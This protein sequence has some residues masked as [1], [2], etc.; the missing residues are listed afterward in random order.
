MM[1]KSTIGGKWTKPSKNGEN[2]QATKLPC[3]TLPLGTTKT[4]PK[5]GCVNRLTL[6]W[7]H[8]PETRVLCQSFKRTIFLRAGLASWVLGCNATYDIVMIQLHI[9]KP[10]HFQLVIST[11]T[12]RSQALTRNHLSDCLQPKDS[13]H[14]RL[15]VWGLLMA[16][17]VSGL[18]NMMAKIRVQQLIWSKIC[19]WTVFQIGA[20]LLVSKDVS[21]IM[22]FIGATNNHQHPLAIAVNS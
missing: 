19:N 6:E 2:I 8:A 4:H 14:S 22:L 18:T 10:M 9:I 3:V 15:A 17:S 7:R 5:A 12:F 16:L 21:S 1:V 11:P 13:W 20:K